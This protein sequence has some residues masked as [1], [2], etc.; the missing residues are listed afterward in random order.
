MSFFASK[1]KERRITKLM[2]YSDF[3]LRIFLD[4]ERDFKTALREINQNFKVLGSEM[5]LVSSSFDKQ[6]KSIDAVTARNKV[7]N[8]EIDAQKEKIST[9]EN[10]LKHASDSF[11]E[12]DKRTKSWQVQLNNANA[13][14]NKLNAEVKENRTAMEKAQNPTEEM[15]HDLAAFGKNA[16]TAGRHTLKM[17]DIIKA[18]LISDAII[19]GI[20]SLGSALVDITR[21]FVVFTKEG[22]ANASNL[23]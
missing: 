7:L 23:A 5:N 13:D 4:G 2:G 15:T 21:K 11:G 1:T 3:G 6:D 10:A 16:D 18:N 9:L 8:K 14:L 20:K 19:S 17:G 12:T 22:V